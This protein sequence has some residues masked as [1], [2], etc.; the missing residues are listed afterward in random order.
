[1]IIYVTHA[2]ARAGKAA[3]L[4]TLLQTL[5][6]EIALHEPGVHCAYGRNAKDADLFV[7]I[8]TFPDAAAQAAHHAADYLAPLMARAGALVEG[9]KFDA[10][11][12]ES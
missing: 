6:A 12:Y 3:D 8:E 9:G 2:R 10:R 7:I 5:R 11:R 4:E 1:L